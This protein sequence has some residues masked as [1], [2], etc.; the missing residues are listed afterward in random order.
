[1]T[2]KPNK[3]V[4]RK[5]YGSIGHVPGSQIGSGDHTINDGMF[6]MLTER[7]PTKN[8]KIWVQEKLDG[9]CTAIAKVDGNILALQRKGYEAH[10]SP[11]P[12][13]QQFHYWVQARAHLF[14]EILQEG[15]RL[16]GEWMIM[17]HGTLYGLPHGPWV[18]FDLMR[19]QDRA[20]YE[21]FWTRLEAYE[22]PVPA[23]LGAGPMTIEQAVATLGPNG[24]HGA[25][26]DDGPEGAIWRMED[27]GKVTFLAK[28]VKPGKVV[29]KYM[30]MITGG[31]E[32]YNLWSSPDGMRWRV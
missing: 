6:A 22:V 27:R 2:S 5:A 8:Q 30:P 4:L 13:L 25:A 15:E 26:D 3:P 19:G 18:A 16:V 29:G 14:D 21:E 17:A 28:Y 10:T 31:E 32:V 1:M 7:K 11:Y 12:F 9:S 23:M 24:F 20:T